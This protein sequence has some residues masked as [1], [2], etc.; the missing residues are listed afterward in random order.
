MLTPNIK[1]KLNG[2]NV[3]YEPIEICNSMSQS[4]DYEEPVYNIVGRHQS[5]TN[6]SESP[7]EEETCQAVYVSSNNV[8]KVIGSHVFSTM[9]GNATDPTQFYTA[10]GSTS[11]EEQRRNV[12][13]GKFTPYIGL[14]KSP[15]RTEGMW[16]ELAQL[17]NRTTP[18]LAFEV[19][20]QDSSPYY[21]VSKRCSLLQTS[22][23]DVY[24]GDCYIITE[25][26]RMNYNF[27]D[28]SYP[29]CENILKPKCWY[30]NYRIVEGE[31]QE[32]KRVTK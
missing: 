13:R 3:T 7:S 25:T 12:V 32:A 10:F 23:V 29:I 17:A 2:S 11:E 28:P 5:I 21:C 26:I 24:R 31:G 6:Y 8:G 14:T 16:L 27:I 1:N 20:A 22:S 18:A 19:R 30:E 15:F 9:I 4:T